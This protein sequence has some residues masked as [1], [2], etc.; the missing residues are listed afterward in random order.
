MEFPKND[1]TFNL[2]STISTPL[3]HND[4]HPWLLDIDVNDIKE[5]VALNTS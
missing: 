5:D 4:K 2:S 3:L 1:L